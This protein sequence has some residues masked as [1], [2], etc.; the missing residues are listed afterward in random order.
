MYE[1][2]AG[3]IPEGWTIDHLNGI[4]ADNRVENLQAVT[5]SENCRRAAYLRVLR[6]KIPHHWQTFTREDYMRFYAMPLD[7]FKAMMAMF[8]RT[9]S[10]HP[11]DYDLTHHCEC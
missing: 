9:L 11:V 10:P 8:V 2:W 7:E 5:L 3:P 1:A 6:E 4:T